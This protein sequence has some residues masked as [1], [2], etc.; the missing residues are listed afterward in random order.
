MP[1]NVRTDRIFVRFVGHSYEDG[2]AWL[3]I[4]STDGKV[5]LCAADSFFRLDVRKL[6]GAMTRSRIAER[7]NAESFGQSR[8]LAPRELL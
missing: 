4:E 5:L 3:G 1:Q 7:L 6:S 8:I 2:S